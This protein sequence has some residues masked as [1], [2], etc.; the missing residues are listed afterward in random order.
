[1]QL[2]KQ[3]MLLAV[4]ELGKQWVQK[5]NEKKKDKVEAKESAPLL[6]DYNGHRIEIH[7]EA[8]KKKKR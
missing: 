2:E 4:G 5:R 1:M 7:Q 6:F 8:K 3:A